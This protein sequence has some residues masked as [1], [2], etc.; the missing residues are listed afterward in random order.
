MSAER[1]TLERLW[2][3]LEPYWRLELVTLA[4]MIA[5]AALALVLPLA[6]Q[7]MIDELVPHLAAGQ[8]AVD[9]GPVIVFGLVLIG[10]YFLNILFSWLRDYLAARIGASIVRDLRSA[11]FERLAHASLRFYHQSSVGEVMSRLLSD[12]GRVQDLLTSTLLMLLTNVLLLTA[13]LVYLLRVNWTLTFIA[14]VPVPLTILLSN[15]FGRRLHVVTRMYQESVARLSARLQEVLAAVPTV[16]AFGQEGREKARVDDELDA[17]TRVTVRS[18]VT[19]SLAVNL[20]HFVNMLGPVV[21][22]AGGTYLVADGSI[23]LGALVAFYI[24][25]S[26]LYQPVQDL[27]SANVEIHAAMASVHRIFEYLDLPPAVLEVEAA[28]APSPVRGEIVFE[29]TQFTY[30]D[31]EFSLDIPS[32]TIRPRETVAIV[33]HSG[34]GK[35]TLINLILRFF[36]PDRGRITIDGVDL[37]QWSLAHLRRSVGLVEQSPVLFRGTLLENIAYAQPKA[38]RQQVEA[39]ARVANIHDFVAALPRGYDTLV[40]ERGVTLSGGEKQ[41]VCLARALLEDPAILVLDEATSAL[42]AQSEHLIQQALR[43]VLT[44]KTAVVIAHRL[45]TVRFADRILFMENGRIV[46]A[47]S[48]EQLLSTSVAYRDLAT[49][50]MM[51]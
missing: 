38:S 51:A 43:V 42:D 28:V 27:A 35:T 49:R 15:R 4:V 39:V 14:L 40:G 37:R 17:L 45:A 24:L 9:R 18:S 20:V 11:L 34:A 6:I 13:V 44:D 2:R 46:D 26:Y 36:D 47:G 32:L 7:Y 33:G 25:L 8:G 10:A 12:V 31:G 48:H 1:R 19:R 21:V 29:D 50:Q 23:K 5:L 30:G 41:R 16:R 22:L 3:C